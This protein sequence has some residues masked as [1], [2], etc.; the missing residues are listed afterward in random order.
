MNPITKAEPVILAALIAVAGVWVGV[1]IVIQRVG[2]AIDRAVV[3]W[4]L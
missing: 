3:G 4:R 2:Q 1:G